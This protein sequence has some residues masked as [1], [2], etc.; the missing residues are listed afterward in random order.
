MSTYDDGTGVDATPRYRSSSFWT[1]WFERVA[2]TAAQVVLSLVTVDQLDLPTE[3][4]PVLAAGL[5][6]VKGFV[7]KMIGN[8]DSAST[9]PS[10]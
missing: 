3:M 5:A 8:S 6:A 7:A 2:W 9:A 1:D 10:V 4:V